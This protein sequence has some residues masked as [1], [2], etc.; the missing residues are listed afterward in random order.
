MDA[1][2]EVVRLRARTAAVNDETVLLRLEV[3]MGVGNPMGIAI[4]AHD[5]EGNKANGNGNI[6]Y[7]THVKLDQPLKSREEVGKSSVYTL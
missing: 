2:G 3:C 6:I 5:G 7:F 1:T 4:M